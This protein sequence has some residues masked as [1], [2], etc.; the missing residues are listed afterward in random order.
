MLCNILPLEE[1]ESLFN[2]P[3]PFGGLAL[4]QGE[5]CCRY[6]CFCIIKI[7]YAWAEPTLRENMSQD[8][9]AVKWTAAQR[10][11]I[12]TVGRMCW[13]RR[14]RGRARPRR[15][16]GA[17]WSG[18]PIRRPGAGGQHPGADVYGRG[19][20]GDAQPD[21]R[22]AVSA[23]LADAGCAAAPPAAAAGPGQYQHDSRVLQARADGVLL[24][25]GARPGVRHPRRRRAAAA[26]GRGAG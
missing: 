14:R 15:C 23:E 8:K 9:Q 5:S 19:G 1:G 11:A 20:R 22:D 3:F 6:S 16:R 13:W 24:P 2:T 25:G 7:N 4:G 12:E 26:E 17:W 21:R 18:L 10:A